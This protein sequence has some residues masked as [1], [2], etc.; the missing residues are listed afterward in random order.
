MGI[1]RFVRGGH[2]IG[3]SRRL[4]SCRGGQKKSEVRNFKKCAGARRER[5]VL[6]LL[7]CRAVCVG[8]GIASTSLR[9]TRRVDEGG[10]CVLRAPLLIHVGL[11]ARGRARVCRYNRRVESEEGSTDCKIGR[12]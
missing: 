4:H 10:F 11:R 8:D 1:S 9:H 3:L 2:G 6:N 7:A 5:R 12:P